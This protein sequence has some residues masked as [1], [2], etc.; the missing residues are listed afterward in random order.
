MYKMLKKL[1]DQ[2]H[3]D[4]FAARKR[5]ALSD[6][7]KNPAD[8]RLNLIPEQRETLSLED[9]RRASIDADKT[10]LDIVFTS[11]ENRLSEIEAAKLPKEI[12]ILITWSK[13]EDGWQAKAE[14]RGLEKIYSSDRTTGGGYDKASAAAAAALNKSNAALKILC[15]AK[16]DLLL[17]DPK[18]A[19]NYKGSNYCLGHGAEGYAQPYWADAVGMSSILATFE[20]CG[21][22]VIDDWQPEI[23]RDHIF[24]IQKNPAK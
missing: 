11:Q 7:I 15:D 22:K 16:E 10:M 23:P 1:L 18:L 19:D 24:L 6:E 21:Y 5:Q 20:R 14:I 12:R 3:A 9:A 13:N 17:K 8:W 2:Y 4:T